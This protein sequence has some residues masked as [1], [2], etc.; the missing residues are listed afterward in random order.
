[1]TRPY[2]LPAKTLPRPAVLTLARK[3]P[4]AGRGAIACRRSG[5]PAPYAENVKARV[6]RTKIEPPRAEGKPATLRSGVR[7]DFVVTPTA[8]GGSVRMSGLSMGPIPSRTRYASY[9][10]DVAQTGGWQG[11]GVGLCK[12]GTEGRC[13]SVEVSAPRGTPES[14]RCYAKTSLEGWTFEPQQ[15]DGKPIDGE[16]TLRLRLKALD[17]LDAAPGGL[18]PGQ[19]PEDPEQ[20]LRAA[21]PVTHRPVAG[22]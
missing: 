4:R 6:A 3:S 15:L 22:A 20:P 14:V 9:P 10:S 1:V 8:Q 12:V 7:I 5:Y 19:V 17:T 16:H 18:P 13:V 2:G 11:E 21:H